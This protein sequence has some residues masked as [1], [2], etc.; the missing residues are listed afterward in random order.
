[1]DAVFDFFVGPSET[2]GELYK[3]PLDHRENARRL[4]C[5]TPGD[6]VAQIV[7]S[8]LGATA[9]AYA[10]MLPYSPGGMHGDTP[11]KTL[12]ILSCMFAVWINLFQTTLDGSSHELNPVRYHISQWKRRRHIIFRATEI[13]KSLFTAAVV[14]PLIAILTSWFVSSD[15]QK[16]EDAVWSAVFACGLTA[17]LVTLYLHIFDEVLRTLLCTPNNLGKAVEEIA[18]GDRTEILLDVTMHSILHSDSSLVEELSG[19][20]KPFHR[21]LERKERERNESAMNAMAN[22]LLHKTAGDEGSA[23]LEEDVLRFYV[24][25][26]LGGA[27]WQGT[28]YEGFEK[29]EAYHME[30]V[31]Q[32]IQPQDK[33]KIGQARVDPLVVR[34]VR[35]LCAYF[36][37]LGEALLI[38]SGQKRSTNLN[39]WVLPPGAIICAE[40]AIRAASRCILFNLSHS[41]QILSDWRS[42]HLSMLI[43]VLIS[44]ACRLET[45]ILKFIQARNGIKD[46]TLGKFDFVRTESPELLSLLNEC[47]DSVTAV[48]QKLKALEGVG[49]IDLE[50]DPVCRTWMEGILAKS[51]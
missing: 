43:P 45:G 5:P 1:V 20:I 8:G 28:S 7:I 49:R 33:L 18:E 42:T 26:S 13:C 31:K 39:P 17:V 25:E 9:F 35:A 10:S 21:D 19:S 44:S 51:L 4:Q 38:C 11:Y 41:A 24:L 36:G 14:V 3:T 46:I 23:R 40:Y 12:L 34:L 48:L 30:N 29:A 50:L 16:G 37:G 6:A 2:P 47:N 22:I 15:F 32:W 27:S